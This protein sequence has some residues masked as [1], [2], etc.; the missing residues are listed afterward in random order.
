MERFMASLAKPY[1]LILVCGPTGSGKSYTLSAALTAIR[2][3]EDKVLTAENPVEY[4]LEGVVQV[5]VNPDLKMGPDKCFDF[6]MALRAFLRQDPDIIMVG[7]IRDKETAQIAME[8]SMTG[9]LVLSTLHTNDA[10]SAI[11]R[12]PEMGVPSFLIANT[13]ECVLAQRLIGTLCKNCK[14]PDPAPSPDLIK[15]LEAHKLDYSKAMFMRPH[16]GGCPKCGSRGMKGRTAINE[17]LQANDE[18]RRLCVKEMSVGPIR[19]ASIR[20]GMR[21]LLEDGLIKVTMGL[22]TFD[23]I[24]AAAT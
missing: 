7:E 17:L 3:P 2:N 8:A 14:E 15:A 20:N 13:I 19:D 5:Q 12:L 22:T 24:M 23:E 10:P 11:S 18:I 1:G 6:G 9:H 4:N 21:P 16:P